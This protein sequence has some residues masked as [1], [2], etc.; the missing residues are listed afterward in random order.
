LVDSEQQVEV[1]N[2]EDQPNSDDA[3]NEKDSGSDYV[4][5]NDN[6]RVVAEQENSF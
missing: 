1:L 6:E 3:L 2:D 5:E 4:S